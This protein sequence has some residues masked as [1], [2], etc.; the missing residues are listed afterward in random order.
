MQTIIFITVYTGVGLN[1]DIQKGLYDRFRSLPMWQP[2]PILGALAGDLFR[3]SM[4]SA[5]IVILGVIIGGLVVAM[6]LPIFRLVT[7]IK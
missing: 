7:L 5:L 2:A 6:Y 4:A 3:Y 1:S